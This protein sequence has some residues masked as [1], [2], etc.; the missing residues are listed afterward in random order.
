MNRNAKK[1]LSDADFRW[2]ADRI[3]TRPSGVVTIPIH[4]M[5]KYKKL[6]GID[7]DPPN[8]QIKNEMISQFRDYI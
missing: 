8:W 6:M 4:V 1:Q 3:D 7:D 5:N 2:I